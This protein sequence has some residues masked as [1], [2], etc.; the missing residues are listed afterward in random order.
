M[1]GTA[2]YAYKPN[3]Q[4]LSKTVN[5]TQTTHIWDGFYIA[6][7][8]NASN[9]ITSRFVRGV[10]LIRS[11]NTWYLFNGNGDVVQLANQSGQ[12]VRD[13]RYDAFGVEG[14][15]D[16]NDANPF[17]YRSEYFDKETGQIYLRA[18]HYNPRTGRFTQPDTYWNVT[19]MIY[20]Y[21]HVKWNKRQPDPRDP[22]GLNLYTFKPD[23]NAIMQ[24]SNLYVYCMN[25]PLMYID[26]SGNIAI[27]A[28]VGISSLLVKA[29]G[30]VAAAAAGATAG[31][32]IADVVNDNTS[33]SRSSSSGSSVMR[34]LNIWIKFPQFYPCI[35]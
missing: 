34:H 25:N 19:N 11:G 8:M 32:A 30:V 24:S 29:V 3:G 35:V 4:R 10:N 31:K 17:R 15:P 1:A 14:S 13:Y 33:S 27:T 7:E 20:G 2:V 6:A 23:I 16:A 5:G 26:P 9:Q 28:A 18:R 12:V 22:L 21:E